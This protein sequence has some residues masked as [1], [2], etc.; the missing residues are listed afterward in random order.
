MLYPSIDKLVGL[1]DSKYSLVVLT[2]KRA[3]RLQTETYNH[4]GA[5]TTRNVSR[6]LWEIND[7]KI[8]SAQSSGQ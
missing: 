5:S 6:A 4:P 2:A 8:T 1:V 7:G 3:R